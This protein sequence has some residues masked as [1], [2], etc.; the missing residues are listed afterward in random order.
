VNYLQRLFHADVFVL[1]DDVQRQGRGVENRNKILCNGKAEWLTIPIRSGHREK[2]AATIVDGN[3]W[4]AWHYNK[5]ISAYK[6]HPFFDEAIVREAYTGIGQETGLGF[7][8]V[9]ERFLRNVCT[10]FG[11]TPNFIRASRLS[12]DHEKAGPEH[13]YAICRAVGATAYISGANGIQYGVGEI[14][15]GWIPVLY[16]ICSLKEYSQYGQQEFVPWLSFFDQI[17]SVGLE[18]T[19]EWITEPLTLVPEEDIRHA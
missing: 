9:V 7:T 13:L 10:L 18:R 8:D 1:L 2:I 12:I 17:F 3:T 6:R 16:N 5:I 11:F 4:V 14:F 19:S 15:A